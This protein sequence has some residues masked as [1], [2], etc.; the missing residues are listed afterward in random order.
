MMSGRC[1]MAMPLSFAMLS[2]ASGEIVSPSSAAA[3]SS[4][5][6]LVLASMADSQHPI[7]M[8]AYRPRPPREDTTKP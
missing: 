2:A 7:S 5:D 3:P 6:Y 1:W 8:A 4:F